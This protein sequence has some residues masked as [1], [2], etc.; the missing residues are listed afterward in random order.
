MSSRKRGKGAAEHPSSQKKRR[1]SG[2][3][4]D[5]ASPFAWTPS[6]VQ[7]LLP[8]GR[9]LVFLGRAALT[10]HSGEVEVAGRLL[11]ARD[12][13]TELRTDA[14]TPLAVSV[15]ACEARVPL[16]GAGGA[17]FSLAGGAPDAPTFRVALEGDPGAPAP[18][19]VPEAWLQAAGGI[20]ESVAGG[21]AAGA[22]PPVIA[23]C[24]AKKVGKST[25]ARYLT[26]VLLNDHPRVAYLDTGEPALSR[27]SVS[28]LF[29]AIFDRAPLPLTQTVVS[30]SLRPL[31]WC[32]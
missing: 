2:H 9:R 30:R 3:D 13:A 29:T 16:A 32:H 11:S 28:S 17:A 27:L 25:F 19:D 1:E 23:V 21:L 22:P 5:T 8:A 18:A 31:V 24:G 12:G 10:V 7:V 20:A 26:N 4:D 14:A 15:A 6:G